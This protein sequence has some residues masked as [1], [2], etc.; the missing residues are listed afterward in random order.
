[1]NIDF[2]SLSFKAKR[3][4]ERIASFK[5]TGLYHSEMDESQRNIVG[6]LIESGLVEKTYGSWSG[7]LIYRACSQTGQ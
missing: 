7:E 3:L 4:Y 5:Q 2:H 1:M 6:V